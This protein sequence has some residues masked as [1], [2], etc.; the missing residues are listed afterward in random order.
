MNWW[1]I[2]IGLLSAMVLAPAATA[3]VLK[4]AD[5]VRFTQA[6]TDNVALPAYE[7]FAIE[8][9]LLSETLTS[10]CAA[11]TPDG[12]H[13]VTDRFHDTMDA[14]AQVQPIL[15]GPVMD[16]PGPARFQFWPDKRGTGQRHLRRAIG[17]NNPSVLDIETLRTASIALG[18]LQALEYVLFDEADAFSQPGAFKCTYASTIADLQR[19]RAAL[20]LQEWSKPNGF[21]EQVI[22]A[23]KG[24]DAFFDEREAAGA[25][26]NSIIGILEVIRL[27]KLERPLGLTLESARGTRAESWRSQR[28]L[29]NIKFNLKTI[30]TMF[31]TS[32]GLNDLTINAQN[33]EASS[34]AMQ[35]MAEIENELAEFAYPLSV[36]VTDDKARPALEALLTR[37]RDLQTLVQDRIARDI[38]LVPGFN[39]TDGD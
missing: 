25:Y 38:G 7:R 6:L 4:E 33:N 8:T 37:F 35:L 15:F 32:N 18:D 31:S 1:R 20:L 34:E 13:A 3:D 21:R 2:G 19:S 26:L 16:A 14:W 27:Q 39:A 23:A 9:T 36:L 17:T 12:V 24:T 22:N 5:Y 29:R 28:S 30:R 11:P 10:V